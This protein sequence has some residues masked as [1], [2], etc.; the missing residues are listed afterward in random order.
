MKHY[1]WVEPSATSQPDEIYVWSERFKIH[2]K[3]V[4]LLWQ[5]G[6]K[7]IESAEKFFKPSV[8]QLHNP[9][10]MADMQKAIDRV[11]H[12][13]DTNQKI[14]VYG[15]YD[16]DGTTA[17]A[18]VYSFLRACN[19]QVLF[20]V[21]DRY[22][23]GYGVSIQGMDYAIANKCNLIITLDCGIKAHAAI[24]YV[25]NTG[26]DVIVCDHHETADTLPSA[27]AVLDPKRSDCE[28][29]F[30]ELSGCGVGYKLL[31]ALCK[32]RG[33]SIK[34][35]L[36]CYLDLLAVSIAS[37]IVPIVDENRVFMYYGLLKI[38][39]KPHLGIKAM[40]ETAGVYG[41][42]TVSDVVFKIGPRIN[43]A[44][45][46][47]NAK[48]VI[49]LLISDNYTEAVEICQQIH[50]YN[51][52]RR[53]IDTSITSQALVMLQNNEQTPHKKTNVLYNSQWH[54]GVIGIVASRV[55]EQFYKPTVIFC[56]EG[57]LISASARSVAEFDLYKALEK[58][59][60]LLTNYGGHTYAAGM[61]MQKSLFPQFVELFESVVADSITDE[62]L[63]PKIK[64][65]AEIE[66]E[67]ITQEF[68]TD[69]LKFAP[70][71][72]HNMTPVFIIKGLT[73]TGYSKTMGADKSH[74]K[75]QLCK[76]HISHKSI[77]AIGFG[78]AQ[79]WEELSTQYP[80]IDICF[81]LREHEFRG[82]KT[83]QLEL[84]DIRPS[85]DYSQV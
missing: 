68:Y 81:T 53:S 14:L 70:F 38:M 55:L 16:V 49:E 47:Y 74:V 5:R 11:S 52:K 59:S 41:D 66:I 64:I 51:I 45:R 78:M 21:P 3:L 29:P 7:T 42:I 62:A 34:E 37:D 77:E 8:S 10:L 30:K 84:R 35:H 60:H 12:A 24:E 1:V 71:G 33:I 2:K 25:S 44:G 50:E 20:Y 15:D 75:L 39:H 46:I 85:T 72:P 43:A 80:A 83:I 58:C 67:D 13:I 17:V 36:N 48:T 26:I 22:A 23:E 65:D 18:M 19:A 56:G 69:M 32:Q 9:L 76:P 61:S 73:N 31:Y 82:L 6:I 4:P 57:D 27:F 40:K 63:V 28:Y 54:K 79:T